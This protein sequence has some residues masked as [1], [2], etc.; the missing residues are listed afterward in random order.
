MARRA[1]APAE[2][3]PEFPVDLLLQL[4]PTLRHQIEKPGMSRLRKSTSAGNAPS[5]EAW[6]VTVPL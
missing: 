4:L 5:A 2:L 6:P 3:A 1:L